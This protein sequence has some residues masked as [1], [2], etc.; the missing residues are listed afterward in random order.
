MI[1]TRVTDICFIAPTEKLALKAK[2]IIEK[3]NEDI[4]VFVAALDDA[5]NLCGDLINKGAKIF[6]SRKGTKAIIENNFDINVVGINISLSDYVDILKDVRNFKGPVGFFSYEELVDGIKPLCDLLNIDARY[7]RFTNN[8]DSERC[9]LDAIK[10]GV[11][12]GIGGS[13]TGRFA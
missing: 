1:M 9:V 8:E 13:V 11:V 7:Y 2:S 5:K 4:Q 12:F 10:D 6:I 3:R